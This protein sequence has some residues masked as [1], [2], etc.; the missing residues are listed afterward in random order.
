M[1]LE[2]ALDVGRLLHDPAGQVRV[3]A[4]EATA[5]LGG[6]HA[7]GLLQEAARSDDP[8]VR[9]AALVGLGEIRR[10]EVFPIL[11]EA[12]GSSDA[13][14]RLVALSSIAAS[15]VADATTI[16][17][18]ACA[19]PDAR[20][21]NAAIGLLAERGGAATTDWLIEQLSGTERDAAL[22]ALANPVEGRIE[23][24]LLALESA[25]ETLA[26]AL[27]RVLLAMRRPAGN[28]AVEAALRLDNVHAR[29]AAARGLVGLDTGAA[30]SA[31][32]EA[33]T[34][35]SDPDVRRISA[36]VRI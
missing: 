21:R 26:E 22:A 6:Q 3:A 23:G 30:K 10:P 28:A 34:S 14:M 31:L 13:G 4:V 19:D 20:V 15:N 29:R 12:L 16:V 1:A 11:T 24:I 25:N 18:R 36:A 33:A 17:M 2:A 35:D 5:K 8:N 9:R 7:L 32:A 27:V